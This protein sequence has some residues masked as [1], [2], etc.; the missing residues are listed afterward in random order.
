MLPKHSNMS[1]QQSAVELCK[2]HGEQAEAFAMSQMQDFM[3]RD[4]AK[5]A[6]HWMAVLQEIKRLPTSSVN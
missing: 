4:D 1:I 6:S 3:D 5:Q 2:L